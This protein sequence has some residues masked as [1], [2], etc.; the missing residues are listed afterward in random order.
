MERVTEATVRRQRTIQTTLLLIILATLPCYC[1]GF[2]LL[3]VAP[4]RPSGT[5]TLIGSKAAGTA[6]PLPTLF[7][8]I[9]LVPFS[10]ATLSPLLP[11][12]TQVN[13][14]PVVTLTFTPTRFTNTPVPLVPTIPPTITPIVINTLPPTPIVAK[15]N[16]PI[17]PTP[18]TA[19]SAT[20]MPSATSTHTHTPT[21]APT[22][23][24]TFTPTSTFTTAPG[25]RYRLKSQAGR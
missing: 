12:P 11:T 16:T 19:P 21:T 10:G 5:P 15:S 20:P 22:A 2:V 17:P 7:P 18:T 4:Q 14:F 6:A 23:T 13:L 24:A 3:G 1:V 25:E 8:T 9:T